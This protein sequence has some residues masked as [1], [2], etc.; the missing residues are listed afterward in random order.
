MASETQTA[1]GDCPT[2]GEVEA[3]R[4]LPR[5]AFP[6]IITAVLRAVAKRRRP[7]RCPACGSPVQ[8]D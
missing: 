1:V 6:P 2:H 7:Y 5:V 3:A 4:E 8:T